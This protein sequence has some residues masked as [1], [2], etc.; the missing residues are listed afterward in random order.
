MNCSICPKNCNAERTESQG[1]G[2]CNMPLN[3]VLAR[4][5]LHVWEEPCLCG[6]KGAGAIF[7]SGCS[8]KC[9]YCQN[10]EISNQ[11]YGKEVSIQRLVEVFKELE[12]KG[13]YCID[14][15]NPTHFAYSIIKAFDK[16][17]PGIPIVYN[18]SGY[19][20]VETLKLFEGIVDIYLPDLKYVSS[21]LSQKYS[22]CTDYFEY[23]QKAIKE[24]KRQQPISIFQNNNM[25]K[26]LI[27]RHLVLPSNLQNSFNALN[28]IKDEL[29]ADTY[30]SLMS[31]Y[32][33]YGNA[34]KHR[35]INRK[36]M[37]AEYT[38]VVDYFFEIGLKNGFMQQMGS[39]SE[40]YI[41]IFDC[42]G[43]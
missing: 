6:D 23:C 7:F 3:P 8:L 34:K 4:A 13:A 18:S 17:K 12:A 2:F 26:G 1:A 42:T 33:P 32:L 43:I 15:V 41:P 16:Y 9:C 21:D 22:A 14:L 24:M 36:L 5:G 19:D 10:Y 37:T 30:V 29:G 25:K 39:S 40:E 28:W 31:Q 11:N 27:I 38:K 35:E 20:K